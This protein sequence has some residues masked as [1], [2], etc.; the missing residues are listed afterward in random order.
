MQNKTLDL[1]AMMVPDQ[2]ASNIA[3]TFQSWNMFRHRWLEEKAELR[4]YIFAT[5]TRK[6]SN[7]SLPWKNSTTIPKICQ[8]RDNL[9]ANYMAALFPNNDWLEWRGDDKDSVTKE[10]A[11]V[12]EAFIENRVEASGFKDTVSRLVYD[13]IDYGN[14]VGYVDYV[15]D[16]YTDKTGKVTPGYVGPKL[17]RISMYDIAFDPTAAEF[18]NT[19]KIVRSIKSLGTLAKEAKSYGEEAKVALQKASEVRQAVAGMASTDVLKDNGFQM[20]G[21]S[22]WRD[23]FDSGMV[24][25]LTFYG[26]MYDVEKETLYENHIIK[27]ID[28]SFVLL[29]KPN[30]NYLGKDY[31]FHIGWRTRP[32]NLYAMGPL[33]NLVGMQYRIDHLEN[34]KADAFDLIAFP[35][36]KIR[37]DVEQFDYMPGEKIYVGDEGDVEFMHPDVTALNADNQINILEQKMEMMAGAPREAMGIRSPGEKTAFEVQTLDNAAGR[38][39]QNKTLMFEG[40]FLTKVLN[41]MLEIGLKYFGE[42]QLIKMLDSELD[43]TLFKNITKEDIKATGRIR[44]VGASHFAERALFVQ[45]LINLLNSPIGADPAVNIHL[46]GI[47]LAKAAEEALNLDRFSLFRPNVRLIEQMESKRMMNEAQEQLGVEQVTDPGIVEGDPA[48][49]QP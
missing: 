30:E 15:D 8:I 43:V 1:N 49:Q 23:Y 33:D 46:S 7:S 41:A 17:C 38:I 29:M 25:V 45:N 20:D 4:N 21:F 47:G 42:Q 37:G 27:V 34:L 35:M 9:H 24:E 18:E 40:S 31:F 14:C 36:M 3:N 2:I 48:S 6:T 39:F 44:P 11:R 12:I 22:S 28:R 5:D 26:D 19:P 10:K 13:W 16:T 32:D